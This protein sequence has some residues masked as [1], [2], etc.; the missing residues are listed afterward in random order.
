MNHS[1]EKRNCRFTIHPKKWIFYRESIQRIVNRPYPNADRRESGLV[2]YIYMVPYARVSRLPTRGEGD[3]PSFAG[4]ND[5]KRLAG[6]GMN[7]LGTGLA[8]N[9]SRLGEV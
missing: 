5:I 2:A 1:L 4:P 6:D 3:P 7:T 9:H 8:A